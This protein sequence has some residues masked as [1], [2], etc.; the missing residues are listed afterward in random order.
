MFFDPII[1]DFVQ[2]DIVEQMINR[3]LNLLVFKVPL[4][5][6]NVEFQW[7][8]SSEVGSFTSTKKKRSE[9]E[10]PTYVLLGS[11]TQKGIETIK[12]QPR[13]SK[14]IMEIA[15]SVGVEFKNLYYTMGRYDVVA[16]AEAPD[17]DVM[18]KMLFIIGGR[19]IARTETLK[20][21]L[22]DKLVE[23]IKELP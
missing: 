9:S 13:R 4:T 21:T 6:T 14:E 19:G 18:T 12:D 11:F 15:K 22:P 1:I 3:E 10:M 16:I 2:P 20:A 5:S 7:N 8:L 23:I 17:D